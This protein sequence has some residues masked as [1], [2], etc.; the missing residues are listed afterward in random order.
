M[1]LTVG[2]KIYRVEH[3]CFTFGFLRVDIEQDRCFCIAEDEEGNIT[4]PYH[5]STFNVHVG[6]LIAE[7]KDDL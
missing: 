3:T 6:G 7:T 2:S 5:G 1:K 4:L